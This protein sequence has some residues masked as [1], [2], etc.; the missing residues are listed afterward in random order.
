MNTYQDLIAVGKDEDERM[1]FVK[2]TINQ[3]KSSELYKIAWTAEQYNKHRNVTINEYQKILYT[4]SGKAIPDMWSANF[5]MACRH[6][7][8]FIV[9]ENQYLLGNG[10]SWENPDTK[11]KLGTDE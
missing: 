1:A 4:V 8:R 7:H 2:Q 5:K 9:Q 11:N 3:H 6:F 10:V